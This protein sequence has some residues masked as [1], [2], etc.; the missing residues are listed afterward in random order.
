MNQLIFAKHHPE[1]QTKPAPFNHHDYKCLAN[2]KFYE[3]RKK[4]MDN[5]TLKALQKIHIGAS[6]H[7][8]VQIYR[9]VPMPHKT[10]NP[11]DWV[12]L[13]HEMAER[14]QKMM[15]I[16]AHVIFMTVPAASVWWDGDDIMSFGYDPR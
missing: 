5:E 3:V 13:S 8:M 9:V 15:K 10:I 16:P 1:Y 14:Y 4:G 12:T 7:S 2:L 11:G 6:T